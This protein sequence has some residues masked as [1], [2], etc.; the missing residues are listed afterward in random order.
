MSTRLAVEPRV[1]ASRPG[2]EATVVGVVVG[3]LYLFTLSGNHIEAEDGLRYVNDV[4]SGDPARISF[5]YHIAYGWVAHTVL[6]LL[7]FVGLDGDP[8]VVMEVLNSIAGAVGVALLWLLVRRVVPGPGSRLAAA[9]ACGLT[10]FAYGYW[11]YSVEVEVYLLSTLV[12]IASLMLAQRAARTGTAGAFALLGAAH[13]LAVLGHITNVLVAF[14]A[15]AALLVVR[16]LVPGRAV[17]RAALA[18]AAA[19]LAVVV[20]AYAWAMLGAGLTG[21]QEIVAWFDDYP[22][23]GEWGNATAESLPKAAFGAGRALVGGHFGFSFSAVQDLL[24]KALPDSD[25]REEVYL[26]RGLSP[27]VAVL[28]SLL[29]LVAFAGVAVLALRWLRRPDLPADARLLARLCLAWFVPFALFFTWWE[30]ENSEFW[31]ATWVPVAVLLALPLAAAR[32][33]APATDEGTDEGTTP[34]RR[35]GRVTLAVTLTALFA[36][37]LLGSVL[38]QHDDGDDYWRARYTW[39][40]QNAGPQDLILAGDYIGANYLDYYT[41]AQVL[42]T[43]AV[44]NGATDEQA[45]LRQLDQLI[46]DSGATRVLISSTVFELPPGAPQGCRPGGAEVCPVPVLMQDL[47]QSD[48]EVVTTADLGEV[49]RQLVGPTAP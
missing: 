12:L 25:L 46:R 16:R 5:P 47:L 21:R 15:L 6:W 38:P 43:G 23:M 17:V 11:W 37:N 35:T 29:A 24:V 36:T 41:P 18:Y 49:V 26:V 7:G 14:V 2:R 9:A 42:R 10:A 28:L 44:F 4:I 40:E 27:V 39:Y 1:A 32:T 33:A 13:G 8:L 22:S 48:T 19:A 34:T 30:P 45:V 3:V 20:P 31:I